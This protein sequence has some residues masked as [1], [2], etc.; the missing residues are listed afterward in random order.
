[1]EWQELL[2]AGGIVGLVTLLGKGVH[3]IVSK[4]ET[5]QE[6][7]T[8]LI[9]QMDKRHNETVLKLTDLVTEQRDL[10]LDESKIYAK[11]MTEIAG[12]L[13]QAH[14]KASESMRPPPK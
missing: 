5:M 10:R 11:D 14:I 4:F 7:Y 6:K 2:G 9:N 12:T 13:G 3:W 8:A 1:M